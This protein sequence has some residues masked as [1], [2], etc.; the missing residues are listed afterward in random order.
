MLMTT[1]QKIAYNT[2]VQ[3]IGKAITIAIALV[4]FGL[5][6]RYLGQKDFGYFSTIYAYLA[7]F[8]ILVD[9]GLQ[10]TTTKLI[11]DPAENEKQ[12]LSNVLAL[13]LTTSVIFLSL[14]FL[15]ALFLPYPGVVK[16]G[17]F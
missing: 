13:R 12:I 3:I 16:L 11:A 1:V 15:V 17:I 10:M 2:G 9:L 7:I 14:A 4:G 6:T 8:G 5:M